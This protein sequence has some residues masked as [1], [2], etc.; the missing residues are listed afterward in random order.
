MAVTEALQLAESVKGRPLADILREGGVAGAGGAGFPTYAKYVKPLPYHLTNAQES[1]P[2]YYI[3]KWLSK[4]KAQEFTE[5]YRYLLSWG[6][7]RIIIAPKYKDREWFLQLEAAT[8]GK[9]FDVRGKGSAINPGEVEEEIVFTYTD[10]MYAFGKEQALILWSCGVKLAARDLPSNHGF[11]VNNT[12]TLWNM[13]RLLTTGQPVTSKYVHV[14]G[15]SPKH[16]FVETPVGT[17]LTDLFEEAG[18]P[19]AEVQERG[20]VVVDGGPGWFSIIE[21][22]ASYSVT[23]RTNSLLILDP[24]YADPKRGDVRTVGNRQG[25]PKEPADQ[26]Q[27]E[28]SKMLAPELVNVRLTDNPEF[29]I[30]KPSV[31]TVERGQKVAAGDVI[32]KPAAEGFSN[33]LHASISGTVTDITSEWITIRR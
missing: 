25:Y 23:K 24:E 4:V 20:F 15:E 33:Y 19:L 29:A 7:E 6:C 32:A 22:P 14:Y 2:G 27:Q 31:P 21:D 11:I 30:I 10:D 9:F 8:G 5:L 28:P 16:I 26:H 12:E 1:E 18:M 17:P 3:D 13:Y